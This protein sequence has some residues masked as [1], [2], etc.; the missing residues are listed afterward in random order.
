MPFNDIKWLIFVIIV[1][2]EVRTKCLNTIKT[3]FGFKGLTVRRFMADHNL[4]WVG[5]IQSPEFV[6]ILK[7][8]DSHK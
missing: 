7:D 8:M 3:S 5:N 2:F 1:Y 4:L 6:T